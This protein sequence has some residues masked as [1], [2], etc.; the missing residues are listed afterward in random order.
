MTAQHT[1][2]GTAMNPPKP[3]YDYTLDAINE[4]TWR[5]NAVTEGRPVPG[6]VATSAL[7]AQSNLAIAGGLL[8]IAD[9][10]RGLKPADRNS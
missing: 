9:A 6:D 1:T 4:T 3:P 5:L 2:P 8:A 10:L 7:I